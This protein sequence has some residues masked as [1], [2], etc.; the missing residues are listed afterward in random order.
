MLE[1]NATKAQAEHTEYIG[2]DRGYA[3]DDW[4]RP[5]LRTILERPVD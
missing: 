4:E 5:G 2:S 1:T 3:K